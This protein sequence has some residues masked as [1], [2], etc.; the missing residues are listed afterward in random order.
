MIKI[1]TGIISI[2]LLS[3]IFYHKN[4]AK[5]KKAITSVKALADQIILELEIYMTVTLDYGK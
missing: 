2:K 3:D 4:R 1:K 5:I